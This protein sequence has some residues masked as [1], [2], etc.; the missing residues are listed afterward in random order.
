MPDIRLQ[1]FLHCRDDPV[2][3]LLSGSETSSNVS[4]TCQL[5][6]T[7]SRQSCS[8]STISLQSTPSSIKSTS[9]LASTLTNKLTN[10]IMGRSGKKGKKA[11]IK[12]TDKQTSRNT[13]PVSDCQ[14]FKQF[15]DTHYSP[16]KQPPPVKSRGESSRSIENK[17]ENTAD[18]L[19]QKKP[20]RTRKA[21]RSLT[22][23]EVGTSNTNNHKK[24]PK[25]MT[26]NSSRDEEVESLTSG[27]SLNLYLSE[28]EDSKSVVSRHSKRQSNSPTKFHGFETPTR[29]NTSASNRLKAL[30]LTMKALE[31]SPEALSS[32]KA[33]ETTIT[34]M[35]ESPDALEPNMK[36]LKVRIKTL[37]TPSVTGAGDIE[38]K[39]ESVGRSST[40]ERKIPRKLEGKTLYS[41]QYISFNPLKKRPSGALRLKVFI[42]VS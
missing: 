26:E 40:R 32:P 39:S 13:S 22:G 30:A 6:T 20:K 15:L 35:A 29:N 9:S 36:A 14:S 38:T 3:C 28:S 23:F 5:T 7:S 34:A 12:V 16:V 18:E 21:P 41:V 4:S 25:K 11:A 1:F 42:F 8:K 17:S 24:S 31:N 2:F 19:D 10:S 37:E 33:L 27:A